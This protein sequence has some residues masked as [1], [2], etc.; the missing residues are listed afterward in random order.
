MK[1]KIK[2]ILDTNKNG[3]KTYQN[4]RCSK[5]IPGGKFIIVNA[6][7][8]QFKK[9]IANEQVMLYLKEIQKEQTK[10]TVSTRK[11]VVMRLE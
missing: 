7:I 4:L 11:E 9:K 5:R 10:P 8:H 2:K 1:S 3:N 6:Y